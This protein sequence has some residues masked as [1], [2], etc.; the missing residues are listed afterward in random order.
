[1][2]IKSTLAHP[3]WPDTCLQRGGV[4][5]TLRAR[6][7]IVARGLRDLLGGPYRTAV[8]VHEAT[9]GCDVGKDHAAATPVAGGTRPSARRCIAHAVLLRQ[10]QGNA[11]LLQVRLS[12]TARQ[13][14][15]ERRE[16]GD[17]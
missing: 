7:M 3:Q 16:L 11:P 14:G 9:I 13:D 4:E 2:R 15:L 6:E 12:T 10:G 5:V 1:E 17:E 8:E